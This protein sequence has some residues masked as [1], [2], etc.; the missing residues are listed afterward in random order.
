VHGDANGQV[1]RLRP[2]ATVAVAGAMFVT[3]CG[4]GSSSKSSGGGS[5]SSAQA[6]VTSAQNAVTNAQSALDK[7]KTTF[8]TDAKTYINA[9]DRYGKV[10]TN[11]KATVGDLR[12]NGA[13]LENP[14]STVTTSANAVVTARDNLAAA[15]KELADAQNALA[16][17]EA[18]A[19]SVTVATTVAPATTTTLVAPA[20]V[21]R[22]KKAESDLTAAFQ[23]VSDQTTLTQATTQ[24]NS[25]ALA[26]E[27]AWLQLIN[28]AGCLTTQQQQ[29]A[30]TAIHNYT[31][32]LQTNLQTAGYYTGP[33]D[34]VYG[35]DTANAVKALQ[36]ANNLPTTGW[37]DQ[38]TTAALDAAVAAKASAAA[39][40]AT[41]ETSAVQSTLK[42]AGYWTGPVDG[43][44]TPEL[45]T[46][47][48]N[49]QT[50]LGVPPTGEVD[51]ATIAALQQAIAN[52]QAGAGGTTTTVATTTTTPT[53]T[54][55]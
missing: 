34:G 21:D 10:F 52:A 9:L 15:N 26:L 31:V 28:E 49:F 11:S 46:A 43:K 29:Q 1:R 16:Q 3:A 55:S 50:A 8:C 4:S 18:T 30:A 25:A 22:V 19:S 35:P 42:L 44:W 39:N 20:T 17:A 48:K 37:A 53:P 33:I 24:V 6:R 47:L 40:Q 36:K 41:I 32:A 38:A 13:D 23:G 27:M 51:S 2:V 45:T 7:S 12:S 5:V 54:S 14:K